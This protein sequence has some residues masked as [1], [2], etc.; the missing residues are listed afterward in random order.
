MDSS[1]CSCFGINFAKIINYQIRP[2]NDITYFYTAIIRELPAFT[3]IPFGYS[4]H[5]GQLEIHWT[6]AVFV[7]PEADNDSNL[8]DLHPI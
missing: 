1:R 6:A 8:V 2:I 5:D 3:Q 7:L 4:L